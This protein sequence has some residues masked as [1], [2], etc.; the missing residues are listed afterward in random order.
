MAEVTICSDFANTLFQQHKRR[1]HM[2][3]TRWSTPKS[4][5]LYSLQP[6]M[7]NLYTANKNKTR[8]WLWFRSWTPYCQ[9]CI[10]IDI[11]CWLQLHWCSRIG[12]ILIK[13]SEKDKE[14]F[15]ILSSPDWLLGEVKTNRTIQDSMT[16]TQRQTDT[17]GFKAKSHITKLFINVLM[18][19]VL[20]TWCYSENWSDL[21]C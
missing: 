14:R 21:S 19:I 20:G 10:N 13:Y 5:W 16:M 8:S 18:L 11:K 2:D 1:L 7:E 6:K 3:I 15:S 17:R 12:S 4:D 9:I